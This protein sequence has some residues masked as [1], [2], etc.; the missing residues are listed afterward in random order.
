[1]LTL[2]PIILIREQHFLK[3]DSTI[4]LFNS[5]HNGVGSCTDLNGGL[6]GS[7]NVTLFGEIVFAYVIK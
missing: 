5:S 1:M 2:G 7:M 6:P 3:D 4:N